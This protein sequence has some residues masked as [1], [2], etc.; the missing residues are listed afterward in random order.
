MSKPLF[1]MSSAKVVQMR[2]LTETCLPCHFPEQP[3][4]KS[5]NQYKKS[6]KARRRLHVRPV[7][8]AELSE[9]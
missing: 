5:L 3:V 8:L 7:D 6:L 4:I 1:E 2:V 9:P